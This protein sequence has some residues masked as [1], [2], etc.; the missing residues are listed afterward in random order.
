MNTSVSAEQQQLM[1]FTEQFEDTERYKILLNHIPT[2]WL[3]WNYRDKYPVDLVLSGHNHGGVIMAGQHQIHG[4]FG[5]VRPLSR[6][7]DQ[8]PNPGAGVVCT[9]CWEIP[10]VHKGNLYR[11]ICNVHPDHRYGGQLRFASLL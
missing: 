1:R 9:V 6:R 8:N 7:C 5:A 3:D 4:I 10:P 2:N 11:E